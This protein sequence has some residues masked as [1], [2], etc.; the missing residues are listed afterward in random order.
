[1]KKDEYK[2]F[3]YVGN[4]DCM[5]CKYANVVVA[6]NDGDI[7]D[8]DHCGAFCPNSPYSQLSRIEDAVSLKKMCVKNGCNE[9]DVKITT[10]CRLNR[11]NSLLEAIKGLAD[12]GD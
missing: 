10:I 7:I 12:E 1:M 5:R 4:R 2:S 3:K 8:R 11:L 6:K 9:D